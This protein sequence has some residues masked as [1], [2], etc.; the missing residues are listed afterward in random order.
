[1]RTLKFAF[2]NLRRTPFVTAVAIL[3]IALG[4]GANTAI[5]SLFDAILLRALPVRD[6]GQLVNFGAP[7]PKPGS[8]SCG[9]PGDC[10]KVFSYLMFRDLEKAE[11]GFSGIAAHVFFGANLAYGGATETGEG[12]LVS[13]SYFPVLGLQAALGRL[14]D[15]ADDQNI[16]GHFVA[17]LSHDYWQNRLGGDPGVL[18]SALIVNGQ[19]L[20]VV[21]VA[22]AGFRGTSLGQEPDVF[23]PLTMRGLMSPGWEGFERRDSYW[24]YL[25][26]RLQDGVSLEQA[27]GQINT[28]YAGIVNEVEAPLQEDMSEATMERF[29][30]KRIELEAG[31]R[32]QSNLHREAGAPL[33][34]L[35]SVTG[36]VL[37]IACANIANLLLARGATRASEMAI[38]GSLGASRVHLLRQLL[39]ESCLLAL[40]GGAASLVVARWTLSGIVALLPDGAGAIIGTGLRPSIIGFAVMLSLITGVL[41][42]LYPALHAT[43]SDLVTVMRASAGQASG[44]RGAARFRA[45]LVVAQLALSTALLVAAGLFL[46]SLVNISRVDLGLDTESVITFAVSPE[47]N[48]YTSD[49][50]A[51]FF[52]RVEDELATIPGARTVAASMV[53]ILSGSSWGTDVFVEGFESGPDVDN[54]ARFNTVSAGYFRA[55][56]IPLLGGR[57]FTNDDA[58]GAAPVAI[59]NEAFARKFGLDP[60]QSVGKRM[61]QS[62]DDELDMEIVGVVQDAKYSDV[63]DAV[64]PLFFVPYRQSE[65]IGFL[66]YYVRATGDPESLLRA[67]PEVMKRLDPNL[68]LEGLQTLDAQI[69]DNVG[70][71]RF[72]STLAT[73]FASLATLLAA[74]GLYGVLAFTVAQRTREFGVRMALGADGRRV[75]GMVL[76]QV[77][78]LTLI[79]GGVGLVAAFALGQAA[80]SLLYEL[81]GH[82]PVVVTLSI[83]LLIA[84]ALG[85][86]YVPAFKASRIDPMRA[87]RYD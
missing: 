18:N 57:E 49:E 72:I 59:I 55:M 78:K 9:Q 74:V 14:L 23:V 32:G 58:V 3:S 27:D 2:R 79:G 33:T 65:G 19:S 37:F 45:G 44:A 51:T 16:G 82:D 10:D 62:S 13:G 34:I 47:L 84:V 64:P 87:L 69:K 35:F 48:A 7:G 83:A 1:M 63:K 67:V 66:N 77:G 20:T 28:V 75:R 76:C 40:L 53:P 36:I 31:E 39:A 8:Q 38:R 22:P 56:G 60:R 85:A 5:F 54:N 12:V 61:S 81:Q 70:L 25:F 15:P 73:A 68:P 29:R 86:A 11:T 26:G 17:V 71:D 80:Q 24:A 42:G 30:A 41:F 4:I 52:P 50:L 43:R 21:G 6:A 46:K